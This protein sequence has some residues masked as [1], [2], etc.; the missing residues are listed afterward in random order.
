MQTFLTMSVRARQLL[1]T[2]LAL[3]LIALPGLADRQ[4]MLSGLQRSQASEMV[5]DCHRHTLNSSTLKQTQQ[6]SGDNQNHSDS[7]LGLDGLCV[8]TPLCHIAAVASPYPPDLQP[9]R[10]V[11]PTP[12]RVVKGVS[13]TEP[14]PSPP[15]QHA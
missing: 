7:K 8:C 15:P 9:P 11:L 10:A 6:A 4:M 13:H 2:V 1:C 14:P 12:A 5:P 3:A